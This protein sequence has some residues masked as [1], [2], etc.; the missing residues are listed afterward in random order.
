MTNLDLV[1]DRL[2]H[3]ASK[4]DLILIHPWFCGATFNRYYKGGAEWLTLPPLADYRLQRLDLFKEQMQL[5]APIQPVLEKME[6]TLRGG[7]TIWLVGHYPFSQPPRPPPRMPRAGEGPSRW[8][9]APYMTAYGMEVTY[10]LQAHAGE[11]RPLSLDV[12]QAVNPFE[13]FP[14]RAVI[15]WR[16]SRF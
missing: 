4:E 6:A 3:E 14:I 2:N 16:P 13:N 7:H 10:F 1:A 5:E 12:K 11:S 9:E 8:N 15:G